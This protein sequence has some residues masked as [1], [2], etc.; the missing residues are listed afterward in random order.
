MEKEKIDQMI[1][2]ADDAL[3][4]ASEEQMKPEE[5]VVSYSI[6]HNSRAS[7]R[8]YLTSYLMKHGVD[9]DPNDSVEE[10][11]VQCSKI[12]DRFSSLNIS[13]VECGANKADHDYEYCLRIN[14]VVGCFGAASEVQKLIKEIS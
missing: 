2:L 10:L 13:E 11:I 14:S 8:M 6:C 5:D 9:P 12:D 3:H 4:M 7:I 1:S